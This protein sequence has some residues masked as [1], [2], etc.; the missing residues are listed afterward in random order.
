VCLVGGSVLSVI[1]T[2]LLTNI[3]PS[4]FCQIYDEY[5]AYVG[6]ALNASG[7]YLIYEN[8]SDCVSEPPLHFVGL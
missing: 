8:P 7:K 6:E 5:F 4:P 2:F 3:A 1:E